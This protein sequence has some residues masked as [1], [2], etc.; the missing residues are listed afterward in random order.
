MILG[1]IGL[2]TACV[3][4]P[5]LGMIAVGIGIAGLFATWENPQNKLNAKVGIVAGLLSL[6]F[7]YFVFL[8]RWHDTRNAAHAARCGS[9]LRQI[10]Q[11]MRQYA[12]DRT[13]GAFPADLSALA[14]SEPALRPEILVCPAGSTPPGPPP[15][16][17][18]VNTDYAYLGGGKTDAVYSTVI[19]GYC[20]TRHHEDGTHMLFGNGSVRWERF[21]DLPESMFDA[22]SR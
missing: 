5:V 13:D 15:Y 4:P 16:V 8:P 12:I 18:G 21:A 10:G 3:M 20:D 17:L 6:A 19:V 7:S 14:A 22:G 2:F 1:V 11:A 9:N